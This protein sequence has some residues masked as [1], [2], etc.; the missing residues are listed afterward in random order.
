[1]LIEEFTEQVLKAVY[2]ND[3]L[4]IYDYA[5]ELLNQSQQESIDIK[6]IADIIVKEKLARYSDDEHTELEI[7]NFGRYWMTKGGYLVFLRDGHGIKEH[8]TE[9]QHA[10]EE[11]L[12]ARLRLTHFRL[13]GFW[14]TLLLAIIGFTFSIVNF[15]LLLK[16]K[17]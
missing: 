15:Y 1:M 13:F 10:K 11:L 12:E 4:R 17:K 6:H 8:H 9:K 3:N 14:A 5:A 2:D 16:G 7:T